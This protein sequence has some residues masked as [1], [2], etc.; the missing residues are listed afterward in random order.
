MKKVITLLFAFMA[1]FSSCSAKGYWTAAEPVAR[2]D[3]TYHLI[4]YPVPVDVEKATWRTELGSFYVFFFLNNVMC[5]DDGDEIIIPA[6]MYKLSH[7]GKEDVFALIRYRYSTGQAY[8]VVIKTFKST[9]RAP[10]ASDFWE[11]KL[12]RGVSASYWVEAVEKSKGAILKEWMVMAKKNMLKRY[13][14]VE[15]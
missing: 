7:M 3:G 6:R 2:A 4:D 10:K 8:Y 9:T 12:S 5:S 13:E 14:F 11:V 15:D 1:I